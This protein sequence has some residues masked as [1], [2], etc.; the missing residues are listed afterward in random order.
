[1]S[2]EIKFRFWDHLNKYWVPIVYLDK[3]GNP[4][5]GVSRQG[6]GELDFRGPLMK[7]KISTCQYTGLKDKKGVEIFEG[8]IV[9][10]K[11]P[12][13]DRYYK[14][15]IVSMGPS[16]FAKDF[17]FTHHDDPS[18]IWESLE[19]LEVVGNIYE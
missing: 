19:Y 9:E 1:M 13:K 14:G 4:Y 8:D 6:D 18:N 10:V 16:F 3:D 17:Y 5:F 12:H 11:H 15:E 7:D 2:R